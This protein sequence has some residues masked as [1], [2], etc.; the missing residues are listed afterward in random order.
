M[1]TRPGCLLLLPV[2]AITSVVGGRK[3]LTGGAGL[4][5]VPWHKT[6][7][8]DRPALLKARAAAEACIAA[9]GRSRRDLSPEVTGAVQAEIVRLFERVFAVSEELARARSFM[10]ENAPEALGRERAEIEVRQLEAGSLH[11]KRALDEAI[12]ALTERGRH[13]T[14]VR[15]EIG[16][17][18]ARLLAASASL[19]AL[20]ARLGRASLSAE[21]VSIR[22][23][24]ALDELKQQEA[25]AKR[26]LEA[27]AAT[28]REIA[29]LSKR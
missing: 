13:A 28:A 20:Q 9:L 4:P 22:A 16:V 12:E 18:S 21:D 10:K 11:E 7:A 24:V 15:N 25:D 29:R 17:L 26:A 23:Q 3:A 19:E 27:Y 2:Y 6:H 14:T 8:E 1:A 5:E